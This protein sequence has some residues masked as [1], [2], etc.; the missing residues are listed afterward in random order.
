MIV[1]CDI[2]ILKNSTCDI[3]DVQHC[4][5]LKS[6]CDIGG[7]M[8]QGPQLFQIANNNLL[9]SMSIPSSLSPPRFVV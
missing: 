2:A 4:H 6:T 5:F 8:H 1:T 9:F 7:P 3:G